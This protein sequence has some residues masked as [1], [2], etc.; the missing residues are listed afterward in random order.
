MSTDQAHVIH[1]GP[2]PVAVVRDVA[3]RYD[4]IQ[5]NKPPPEV[6]ALARVVH[7]DHEVSIEGLHGMVAMPSRGGALKLQ[8][9]V[10]NDAVVPSVQLED[11]SPEG[12]QVDI[13]EGMM[14]LPVI[15]DA[16]LHCSD[17]WFFP[18]LAV[19]QEQKCYGSAPV[20]SSSVVG[21]FDW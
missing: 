6:G 13:D 17:C 16:Q 15:P 21:S 7:H 10:K 18:G 12:L 9:R 5:D 8:A 14:L 11:V 1:V 4:V 3:A 19:G 2:R 20:L